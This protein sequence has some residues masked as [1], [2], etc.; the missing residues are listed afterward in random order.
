MRQGHAVAIPPRA[1]DVLIALVRHRGSVVETDDLMRDVWRGSIV[2]ENNLSVSISA[3][4]KAL[5][6][7]VRDHRYIVTIHRRGYTFVAAV[8]ERSADAE[9]VGPSVASG[10]HD[11]HHVLALPFEVIGERPV[12]GYASLAQ[13]VAGECAARLGANQHLAVLMPPASP[14]PRDADPVAMARR[15]DAAYVLPGTF[16][17][18]ASRVRV[19]ARLLKTEDGTVVWGDAF[20]E[21]GEDLFETE[22]RIVKRIV[23]GLAAHFEEDSHQRSA[24]RSTESAEAH[25]DYVRGRYFWNKRTEEGLRKAI[26]HFERAIHSDPGYALPYSGLADCYLLLSTYGDRKSTRL[27]SSHL[28]I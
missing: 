5:G 9:S 4:R 26:E 11:R 10:P 17:R 12:P 1:V 18:D 15:L 19:M 24:R 16:G 7:S 13:A 3:L 28:G 25:R 23:R 14:R 8:T 2:E 27:N 6:E 20:D 22:S 21:G